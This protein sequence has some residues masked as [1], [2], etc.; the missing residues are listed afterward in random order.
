MEDNGRRGKNVQ[1]EGV[2]KATLARWVQ[3]TLTDGSSPADAFWLV[4][5]FAGDRLVAADRAFVVRDEGRIIG[6]VTA[7]MQGETGEGPEIIGLY[8]LPSYRGQGVGRHLFRHAYDAL[9]ADGADTIRVVL[10]SR[11]ARRL[12]ERLKLPDLEVRDVGMA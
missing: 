7:S 4:V 3:E 1:V 11:E 9:K 6:A 5:L 12:V 2:E 8:V 10:L